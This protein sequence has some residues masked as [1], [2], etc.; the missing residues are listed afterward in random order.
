[1]LV[2]FFTSNFLSFKD[3]VELSMIA[4]QGRQFENHLIKR[5]N[6][7]DIDIL[8]SAIIYGANASGKS[9]LIKAI[10]FA[11]KTIQTEFKSGQTIPVT[12][13]KLCEECYKKPSKF[14]F[15]YKIEN[16][17]YSYGFTCN[18]NNILEEWLFEI[19]KKTEK[20][21]FERT[22]K[23]STQ[24]EIV[25]N[26]KIFNN[27]E[28]RKRL[29]FIAADTLPNQLFL[30]VTN[31]RNIKN[32]LKAKP[33]FDSYNWFSK[34]LTVILPES[35]FGGLEFYLSED[36]NFSNIFQTFLEVFDTGIKG[37]KSIET[38]FDNLPN[39]IPVKIK[40][41]LIE[42]LEAGDR[43]IIAGG[44]NIRYAIFKDKDSQ[45]KI[46][47]LMAKHKND[48]NDDIYFE[49]NEESDGTQR[50]IDF[51]PTLIDIAKNPKVFVIDEIDRSLHPLLTHKLLDLFYKLSA[52]INSQII[53][54][55]HETC[56]LDLKFV[57]K[58]EIW[59]IYKDKDG[60][61][62]INSLEQFKPRSDLEIRKGY[63]LGRFGSIPFVKKD[64]NPEW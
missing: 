34:V 13:F 17:L 14:E 46:F 23:S 58:D 10:Q 28:E 54:A 59:F 35:K 60:S 43:A 36:K 48:K 11:Q 31:K 21:I 19:G 51:I 53:L 61:S 8:K 2:R 47:K 37:I 40:N 39:D 5:Q 16:K 9:N 22:T 27:L 25:F 55:S 38:D 41:K 7:N 26:K 15:E 63:L 62:K 32:I 4:G 45:L 1:M 33:I 44:N 49:I 3:E 57:R 18:S 42:N 12:P 64:L 52:N 6:D 50:L 30:T 20:P 29:E 56:L 24:I